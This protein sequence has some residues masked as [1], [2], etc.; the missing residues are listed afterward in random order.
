MQKK[1]EKEDTERER[2]KLE[3]ISY[4]VDVRIFTIV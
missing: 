3:Q 1:T 4:S 2:E